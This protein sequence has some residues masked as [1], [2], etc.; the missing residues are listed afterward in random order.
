VRVL[1]RSR[2]LRRHAVEQQ[3]SVYCGVLGVVPRRCSRR[4]VRPSRRSVRR[5][6]RPVRRS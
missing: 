6:V 1:R 4:S 2:R 3:F 5:S